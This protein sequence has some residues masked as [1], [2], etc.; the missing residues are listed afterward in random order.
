MARKDKH[1]TDKFD[2]SDYNLCGLRRTN[3]V[4]TAVPAEEQ[5]FDVVTVKISTS[6]PCLA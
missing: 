1:R 6:S 2:S 4:P 5:Y 3:S